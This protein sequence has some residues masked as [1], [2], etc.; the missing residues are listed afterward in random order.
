ME[1]SKIRERDFDFPYCSDFSRAR[2]L[3]SF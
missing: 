3:E 1:V 2:P